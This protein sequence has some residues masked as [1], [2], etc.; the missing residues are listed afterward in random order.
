MKLSTNDVL[1]V[2]DL[3][4]ATLCF[5]VRKKLIEPAVLGHRGQGCSDQF[6]ISQVVEISSYA[7]LHLTYGSAHKALTESPIDKCEG[8]EYEQ[9]DATLLHLLLTGEGNPWVEEKAAADPSTKELVRGF[10]N[11]EEPLIRRFWEMMARLKETVRRKHALQGRGDGG[12]RMTPAK[13][14]RATRSK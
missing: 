4:K 10:S 5:W 14:A 11:I 3:S 1:Y 8:L 7:A 9:Q 12:D 6:T 2:T 13:K